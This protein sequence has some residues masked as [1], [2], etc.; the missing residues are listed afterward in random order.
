MKVDRLFTAMDVSASGLAAQRKR[1]N[2]IAEN[3]A[4]AET[5][6]TAEGG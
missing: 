3:L 5:T 6:R 2:A 1:M 4:N